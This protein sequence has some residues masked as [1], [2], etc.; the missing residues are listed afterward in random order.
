MHSLLK[1]HL[2]KRIRLTDEEI[3]RVSSY[4]T[5]RKLRKGHFL[6]QEGEVCTF[7]TYVVRGALRKYS[8]DPKGEEHIVQFAVR[9]WWIGD[10]YSAFTG[11]PTRFYVDALEDSDILVIEQASIEKLFDEVPAFERFFRILLQNNHI[12]TEKRIADALSLSALERYLQFQSSFPTIEH[13][14]PQR[15]IASYLGITPQSL[16][17]IRRQRTKKK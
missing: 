15:H 2:L 1:S 11:K 10:M 7:M 13:C 12:A 14:V 17:R 4:V 8:V 9:D 16:S 6:F 5:Q 3:D